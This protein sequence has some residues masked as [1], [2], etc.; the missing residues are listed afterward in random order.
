M[1]DVTVAA[2]PR[3]RFDR[4]SIGA[5]T[6]PVTVQVERGRLRDLA[7]VLGETDPIH[8]RLEAAH[9]AGHPDLVAGPTFFVVAEAE[10][11]AVLR[12]LGE[13]TLSDLIRPDFRYLLHGDERYAYRG[14]V[15]AGDEVTVQSQ[16]VDFYDRKGG[17][18]EF[19]TIESTL[20]HASRG[21]LVH[22]TRTLLHR[23][24]EGEAP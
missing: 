24:P 21:T 5:Y 11:N 23:L 6:R 14:L 1:T 18:M 10:A 3:G 8:L 17:A 19:V 22:A 2:N 20:G 7:K 13:P 9:A 15:F 12:E 4:S 16:V